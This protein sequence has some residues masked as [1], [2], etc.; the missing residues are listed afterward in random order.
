MI[1]PLLAIVVTLFCLVQ[2]CDGQQVFSG[3]VIGVTDGDTIKVFHDGIVSKIRL[4]NIDCPEHNQAFGQAA[5]LF[6]SNYVFGKFVQIADEGNDRYGRVIGEVAVLNT[7]LDLNHALVA[8]GLAW[9]YR[10]YCHD[11]SFYSLESS[12]RSQHIGLWSD[13]N[14]QAP[15]D[16]R[17]QE[18]QHRLL[19]KS[20]HLLSLFH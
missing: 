3:Q 1:I 6:T 10:Q 9:A 18:K 13:A 12:A 4:A 17:K 20:N 2:P 5:K 11:S 19:Y 7:P 15:W 8:Y 16:F 14:A